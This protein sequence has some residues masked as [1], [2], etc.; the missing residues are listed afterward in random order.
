M[1]TD[2][3]TA[4]LEGSKRVLLFRELGSQD[5]AAKLVFQ[6][7]HTFSY[8]RELEQ[9]ETKDGK[10]IQVGGLEST[11]A[12]EALQAKSDPTRDMLKNSVINGVMLELWEV[13][14]DPDL[15]STD[16]ENAGKYPAVYCQGYL[17]SWEDDAEAGTNAAIN[18]N[19]NVQLKPQPGWA[20][21]TAEQI[22]AAQYEFVDTV[23]VTPP[24][25]D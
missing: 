13:T 8:N 4:M 25:G 10:V 21:M 12:I 5:K 20:T 3:K 11:V 18:S 19:F 1:A 6:R 17:D 15:V 16:T 7:K 14:V 24:I 22:Q 23:A 2:P 9:I